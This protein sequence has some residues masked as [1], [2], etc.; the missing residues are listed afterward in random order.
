M[1][2]AHNWVGWTIVILAGGHAAAALFHHFVLRDSLLWR[3]LPGLR[4][5][6]AE[7]LKIGRPPPLVES[8]WLEVMDENSCT[9]PP[10]SA[11]SRRPRPN[12]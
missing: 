8:G 6:Q 9:S 3:M 12:L 5:H 1:A 2:E 7:R 4:A 10:A 11:P